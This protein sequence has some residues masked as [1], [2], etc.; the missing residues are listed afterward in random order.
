MSIISEN[1]GVDEDLLVIHKYRE[2]FQK[3]RDEGIIDL[4]KHFKHQL[5]FQIYR[6]EDAVP[7]V[8]GIVP[9]SRQLA[10][11][12]IDKRFSVSKEH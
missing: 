8:W 9:P 12:V 7:I 2:V 4:D 3:Y 1:I 10:N 5:N 11:D 6:L